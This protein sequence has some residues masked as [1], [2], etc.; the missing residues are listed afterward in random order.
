M[1]LSDAR[2]DTFMCF[3]CCLSCTIFLYWKRMMMKVTSLTD[4]QKTVNESQKVE[5]HLMHW[6]SVSISLVHFVC[7]VTCVT[8]TFLLWQCHWLKR[9]IIGQAT[10]VCCAQFSY[11]E[12]EWWWKW[13][14]H[15]WAVGS[16]W[17]T[18][19][20]NIWCT[21]EASRYHEWVSEWVSSFL[22][23]HQHKKVI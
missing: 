11:T 8:V 18:K 20:S 22:M 21:E 23:A 1:K 6:R 19:S 17:V 12:R 5:Q 7:S 10:D 16:E 3:L 2:D 15:R 13:H 14:H 9:S 4:K